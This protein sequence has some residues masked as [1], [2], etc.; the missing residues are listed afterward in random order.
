M[1]SGCNNPIVPPANGDNT[2]TLTIIS[3]SDTVFGTVYVDGI[4]TGKTLPANDSVQ[5]SGVEA[6]STISLKDSFGFESHSELFTPPG[7]NIVFT[8]F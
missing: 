2:N 1:A 8:Y 4:S 6:G 3:Q 5:I 7:T